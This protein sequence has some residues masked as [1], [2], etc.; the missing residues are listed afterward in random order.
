MRGIYG[1]WLLGNMTNK[2]YVMNNNSPIIY[3]AHYDDGSWQFSGN[4]PDLKDDDYMVVTLKTI[5]NHDPTV[6]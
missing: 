6:I 4:Q 3:V 2:Y 5:P 1:Y